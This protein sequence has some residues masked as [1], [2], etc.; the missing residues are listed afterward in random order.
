MGYK[1]NDYLVICPL[2]Q[3]AVISNKH[4]FIGIECE[5][6]KINLGFDTTR[7]IRLRS[8]EELSDYVDIFCKYNY[9]DCPYYKEYC[10]ESGVDSRP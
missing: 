2:F 3:N 1:F 7:L 6:P 9:Y 4:K 10:R 5:S 8:T